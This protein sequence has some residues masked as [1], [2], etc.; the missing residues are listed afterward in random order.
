MLRV[1][2]CTIIV[3]LAENLSCIVISNVKGAVNT[4]GNNAV[5]ILKQRLGVSSCLLAQMLKHKYLRISRENGQ[6]LMLKSLLGICPNARA[7]RSDMY[8]IAVSVMLEVDT[9]I[10]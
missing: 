3:V 2:S 1:P 7:I 5:K 9:F 10:T 6:I 8:L 4:N